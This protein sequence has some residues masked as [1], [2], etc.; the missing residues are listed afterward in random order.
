MNR[1]D[2]CAFVAVAGMTMI[3]VF[4]FVLAH[5]VLGTPFGGL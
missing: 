5:V 2:L 3:I 4:L 1:D